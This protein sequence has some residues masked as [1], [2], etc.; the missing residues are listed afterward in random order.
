M[1][2]SSQAGRDRARDAEQSNQRPRSRIRGMVQA[3]KRV[4][5]RNRDLE[6]LV[7]LVRTTSN[8]TRLV[9]LGPANQLEVELSRGDKL[10]AIGDVITVG[11]RQVMMARAISVAERREKKS[12]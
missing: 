3:A 4:K 11:D 10:A 6:H 7:A 9:D 2:G 12:R 5:L 8:R 1:S